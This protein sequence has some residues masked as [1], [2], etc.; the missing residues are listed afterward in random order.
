MEMYNSLNLGS[1][2]KIILPYN[3]KIGAIIGNSLPSGKNGSLMQ[4]LNGD[5]KVYIMENGKR[6]WIPD[7]ETFV[8]M[9]LKPEMVQT[10]SGPDLARIPAGFPIPSKLQ[11]TIRLIEKAVYRGTGESLMYIVLNNTLKGIPDNETLQFMGYTINQVIEVSPQDLNKLSRGT[12]IASRRNGMLVKS[13]VLPDVF[14]MENGLRRAIPDPE[15]FN[16][17]G[18]DWNKIQ[19]IQDA[20]LNM[21]PK[22]ADLPSKK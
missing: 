3:A 5:G 9:G 18:Y 20:E 19:T 8:M 21:I 14:V 13:T 16:A 10:I 6:R 22:G 7:N 2:Q 17:L 1:V 11:A 12:G 4:E 15:T